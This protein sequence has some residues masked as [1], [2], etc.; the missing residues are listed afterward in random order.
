MCWNCFFSRSLCESCESFYSNTS[1]QGSLNVC[2]LCSFVIHNHITQHLELLAK[3]HHTLPLFSIPMLRVG[4]ASLPGSHHLQ[5]DVCL[6]LQARHPP[7]PHH[8]AAVPQQ[9][10]LISSHG[11]VETPHSHIL[12]TLLRSAEC[13]SS[14]CV[15]PS[16]VAWWKTSTEQFP[17]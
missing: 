16:E 5:L 9:K 10:I 4:H 2:S 13:S 3:P 7:P 11:D 14:S 17:T 12:E 15:V 6:P 1:L 8:Q